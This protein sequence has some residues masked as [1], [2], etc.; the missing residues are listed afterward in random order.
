MQHVIPALAGAPDGAPEHSRV[1][2]QRLAASAMRLARADGAYVEEV[3]PVR[4]HAEVVAVAG[5][6]APLLGTR[7]PLPGSL[8]EEA[9]VGGEPQVVESASL[10]RRPIGEVVAGACGACTAL[11]APLVSGGSALGA[12]VLLRGAEKA[13]FSP[14]EVESVGAAAEMGA[15]A[16]RSLAQERRYRTLYEDNPSIYFTVDEGETIV[17]VNRFGAE[18]LGYTPEEL[19]GLPVL[20]VVWPEDHA[21]FREHVAGCLADPDRVHRLEFRKLH[22]SGSQIWVRETLRGVRDAH[23]R[24]LVLTV[25]EDITER[26]RTEEA[27][28]FDRAVLRAQSEAL[29]DGLLVVSPDGRLLSYNQSF[30]RVWGLP[31]EVVRSGLDEEALRWAAE[32][33]V[34]PPAFRE[35][36]AYLY[37]HPDEV[38]HDEV[39]L[40]DGRVFDRYGGPV[41]GADGEYY[42]YLWFFREV[43]A[44]R[45]AE[46]A[47]RFLAEAGHVLASSLDY[48][49][50]LRSLAGLAVP[51][52]ADW[53]VVDLCGE[54]EIRRMAVAH[55]DP[56]RAET[57]REY[58]RRF[59]PDPDAEAGVAKVIRTGE[60]SLLPEIPDSLLEAI[61]RDGEQLA[62]LREMGLRSAMIVPLVARGRVLGAI[63]LVAA[64][65][66]RRFDER[67]LELARMLAERAALSVDKA[68]L[69]RTAQD[70]SK[71]RDE[72]L[73]IVSHD[74][75]N[76]LG[77]I[78]TS[79]S[80]V[81]EILPNAPPAVARQLQIIRRQ[82][83][84]ANRLIQD[85][86]DVS[87][88][89]A[90]RLPIDPESADARFLVLEACESSRPLAEGRGL[91]LECA[92]VAG[93]PR[94]RADRDRVLQAFG[95]LIG[96]AVKFTP[97]RGTITVGAEPGEG[98]VHFSVS[99]TGAGIRDEDLPHLFDRFYQARQTRRGGA[100]LGLA[101]VKGIVEAHG[102]RVRVESRV[103]E[104]STFHFTLPAEP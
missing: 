75:R 47:Q 32:Q 8:A 29:A 15:L 36:V 1:L 63:T 70:A 14:E 104:G 46:E 18:Y 59:P 26:I 69:Y 16:L 97:A 71:L 27:L 43:T 42:G 57:A 31:E 88:M 101:I 87:R 3:D 94:V 50:T 52:L 74:L 45:R 4:G 9:T 19:V 89:E 55:A 37:A 23:G 96:N 17:G 60:P 33:T 66:G 11:V 48:E 53:C 79:V 99:D 73:S 72:V 39:V 22:R 77:T 95:N 65:S 93:L 67:D 102:G 38:S 25:C 10:E 56:A 12:L 58:Q 41:K 85:L 35:R 76:P 64:E 83:E 13:L 90:G 51:R 80:F 24:M 21:R 68:R 82:A 49:T 2:M 61:A 78:L 92:A 28:R 44:R 62:M 91:R 54:G 7:V 34:D 40:R 20:R 81:P 103:G 100:G 98:E 84:Q 5:M 6:G 86:L 30:I